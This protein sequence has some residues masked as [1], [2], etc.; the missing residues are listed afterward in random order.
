MK[1]GTKNGNPPPAPTHRPNWFR[2]GLWL[3]A[4]L[5]FANGLEQIYS[6]IAGGGP[7]GES[8]WV[9]RQTEPVLFWIYTAAYFAL[10][11]L[12]MHAA[13][14]SKPPPCE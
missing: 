3:L 8:S 7:E 13:V 6:G 10:G 5:S 4:F 12:T 9:Y 11:G 2:V 14:R 1:E